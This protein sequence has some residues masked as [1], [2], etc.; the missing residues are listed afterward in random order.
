[1]ITIFSQNKFNSKSGQQTDSLR[2]N[3]FPGTPCAL[4]IARTRCLERFDFDLDL[5]AWSKNQNIQEH[6]CLLSLDKF[7]TRWTKIK[8]DYKK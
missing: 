8:S 4:S 1:M 2:Q 6:I 3:E 7:K 5:E